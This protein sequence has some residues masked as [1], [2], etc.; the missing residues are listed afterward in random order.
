M[1]RKNRIEQLAEI[2]LTKKA[3]YHR[4]W[5]HNYPN[6]SER[7][8]DM[9]AELQIY[10]QYEGIEATQAEDALEM[11]AWDAGY[12]GQPL[13]KDWVELG[14]KLRVDVKRAYKDGQKTKGL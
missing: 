14:K 2:W 6:L 4:D 1:A 13:S 11:A 9:I 5:H 10:A 7:I 3:A 12:A 8:R